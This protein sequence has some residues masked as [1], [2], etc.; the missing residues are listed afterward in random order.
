MSSKKYFG[1][2]GIRGVVGTN[3]I[4]PEF[5]LKLGWVI[6]KVLANQG[7]K[8]I[9][10]GSDTRISSFTLISAL[11]AGVSSAGVSTYFL[12]V[13]PTPAVAYLTKFFFAEAGVVISASHNP[14]YYNGI[15]L[16]S[17]YGTKIN[18]NIEKKIEKKIQKKINCIS[19]NKLGKIFKISKAS[20]L[21]INF[22]KKSISDVL[23]LKKLKIILD[24][25]N[26][27]T[28]KI[29]PKILH[30]LGAN[31]IVLNYKPNGININK[32]CGTNN[33]KYLKSKV[34]IEKADLGIAFDGDGD[35]I[36]MVDHLGNIINGDYILYIIAKE[37]IK[38][39]KRY[40]VVGTIMSNLG[41]E[42]ALKKIGISFIRTS[43]GDRFILEKLKEKKWIFGAE[44]SGHIIL[45]NKTTT[46]DGI[47]ASLQI[48]S[49]M[50]KNNIS[51]YNLCKNIFFFH[52]V[53]LN[54]K[55]NKKIDPLK[56]KNVK[57]TINH[58]NKI[59]KD[60]G[61]I[62]VRKSGTEPLIRIMIEGK[63]KKKIISLSRNIANEI[64]KV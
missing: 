20:N 13:I 9:V 10:L 57:K 42:I 61:R 51:L 62:L 21:Y 30:Q 32:K 31:L 3:P 11:E 1:T 15:K 45:L 50:I 29:A 59:L 44:N 26:G 43:V 46:S 24:C 6:G 63:N 58:I 12:G 54:V 34:L 14:Y 38:N 53:L 22:C 41:L 64:R 36:I 17:I 35:R 4:T 52:Q 28:Y 18:K 48:L 60:N 49:I 37:Y 39:K 7:S 27:S 16:F 23:N 40:G 2:D 5:F 25:S 55:L 33:T 8:K 56:N 19:S 47:I